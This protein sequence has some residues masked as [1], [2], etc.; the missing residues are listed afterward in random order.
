MVNRHIHKSKWSVLLNLNKSTVVH[1]VGTKYCYLCHRGLTVTDSTWE[2]E[3]AWSGASGGWCCG[4]SSAF[5]RAAGSFVETHVGNPWA[6]LL[7]IH[8]LNSFW[9]WEWAGWGAAGWPSA[10]V[11]SH[12]LQ[13]ALPQSSQSTGRSWWTEDGQRSGRCSFCFVVGNRGTVFDLFV[14]AFFREL[15]VAWP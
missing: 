10:P 7:G 12:Q 1:L 15:F 9:I 4:S 13:T 3:P 2:C 6:N 11:V 14:L 8:P 5:W